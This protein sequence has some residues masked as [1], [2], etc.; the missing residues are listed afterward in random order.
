MKLLY[1]IIGL[2]VV[3]VMSTVTVIVMLYEEIDIKEAIELLAITG[4]DTVKSLKEIII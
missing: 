4:K 2:I 3:A 1:A